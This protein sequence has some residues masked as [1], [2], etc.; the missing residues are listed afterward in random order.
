MASPMKIL[1]V[2]DERVMRDLFKRVLSL[3]GYLVT[4]VESGKEAIEKVKETHFDIAFIDVVMPEMDG[5]ETLRALKK[6]DPKVQAVIS[7]V[8]MT[9]FAVE[10]EIKEAMQEGALDYL[11]KP[12]DIVEIM[13]VI[14]KA[15]RKAKLKPIGE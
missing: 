2:D 14:G 9:G 13:T 11:Y 12:F 3:K 4:A 10:E 7:V 8:M 1:V 6:I 15:E 5:I